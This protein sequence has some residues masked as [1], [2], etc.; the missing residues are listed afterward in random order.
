MLLL[1]TGANPHFPK[2]ASSGGKNHGK[3]NPAVEEVLDGRGIPWSGC[4]GTVHSRHFLRGRGHGGID[5][6][7][8]VLVL[9]HFDTSLRHLQRL[10]RLH[11]GRQRSAQPGARVIRR[12]NRPNK[13]RLQPETNILLEAIFLCQILNFLKRYL[14]SLFGSHHVLAPKLMM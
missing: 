9:Q 3:H 12:P 6:R 7:Q 8:A 4:S 11:Q 2:N 13:N 1:K 10:E 14:G 5:I